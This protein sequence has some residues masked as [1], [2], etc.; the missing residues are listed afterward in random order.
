MHTFVDTYSY[1]FL[2]TCLCYYYMLLFNSGVYVINA[3][4]ILMQIFFFCDFPFSVCSNV[5][6]EIDSCT[7]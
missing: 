7:N 1:I 4:S 6:I 3:D 2:Y 5:F